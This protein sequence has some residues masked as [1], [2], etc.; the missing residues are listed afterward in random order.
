M[1][2]T[3]EN[4]KHSSIV[5]YDHNSRFN[6]LN[7][8]KLAKNH[9]HKCSNYNINTVSTNVYNRLIQQRNACDF[10]DWF[11]RTSGH[12]FT[13]V[14]TSDQIKLFQSRLNLNFFTAVQV[15][16]L[17]LIKSTNVVQ[18][19]IKMCIRDR[20]YITYSLKRRRKS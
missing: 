5:L 13:L 16:I 10:I 1:T 18:A 6:I 7:C 15:Q 2:V 3:E 20:A 12:I 14:S 4:N 19:C 8:N 9:R 17:N 11:Y